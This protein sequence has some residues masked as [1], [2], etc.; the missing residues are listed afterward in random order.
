MHAR[1]CSALT[2]AA[3][4]YLYCYARMLDRLEC[5]DAFTASVSRI[6]ASVRHSG[7]FKSA[8]TVLY[9]QVVLQI[10]LGQL[11]SSVN[12]CMLQVRGC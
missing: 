5:C 4:Q 9:K 3:V 7:I 2:A 12:C 6:C 8:S 1:M 10:L 11:I